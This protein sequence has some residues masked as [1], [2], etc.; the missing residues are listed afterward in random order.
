MT[1]PDS[2]ARPFICMICISVSDALVC[3]YGHDT[4]PERHNARKGRG[5]AAEEVEDGIALPNLI[6]RDHRGQHQSRRTLTK[7]KRH[8]KATQ[9]TSCI[10][11]TEK[12]DTAGEE[13]SLEDTKDDAQTR[14]IVPVGHEAHP[15]HDAAPEE[16]DEGQVELGADQADEE[17]GGWLEDH[18]GG[19]EGE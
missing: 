16:G 18:I 4:Y 2:P 12:V 7:V 11:S 3:T 1:H 6:W 19:E 10:P 15:D 14:Q 13:P 8:S 17:G 9:L 5:H